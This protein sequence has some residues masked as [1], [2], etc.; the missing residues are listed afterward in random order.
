[1]GSWENI[2]LV[3][4]SL[5]LIFMLMPRVKASLQQSKEAKKDWMGVII[6]IGAVVLFVAL[7]LSSV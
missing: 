1:M 2:A 6:P 4:I 7:L 5:M 3:G